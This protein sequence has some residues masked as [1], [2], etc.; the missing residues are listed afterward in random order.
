MITN[1]HIPNTVYE[2]ENKVIEEEKKSK[3]D[4]S[5]SS[6]KRTNIPKALREQVWIKFNGTTFKHK[7]F[8]SWCTNMIT[9]FNYE[10]GH[11]IPVTKGGHTTIDNLRPICSN[12]NKSMSNTYTIDEWNLLKGKNIGFFSCCGLSFLLK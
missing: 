9:V 1:I 8:V 5:K 7:C 11:N 10:C 3:K 2:E 4:E 6:Q 12:C